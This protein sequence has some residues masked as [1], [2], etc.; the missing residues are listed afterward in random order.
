MTSNMPQERSAPVIRDRR[1]DRLLRLPAVRERTGLSTPTIYRR[2]A[3]GTFPK[4]VKIG[5]NAVAWYESDIDEFVASP[6]PG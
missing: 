6:F 3:E 4:S 1:K 2:Q 5:L